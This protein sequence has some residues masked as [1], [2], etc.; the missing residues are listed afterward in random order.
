MSRESIALMDRNYCVT[1]G[2][3]AGK[4][5]CLVEAYLGLVNG[6]GNRQPLEPDQVVA[7]T[8]TEKAAAEMRARVMKVASERAAENGGRWRE[9]LTAL[10]WAPITTIHSFC[11]TVLRDYGAALGIDPDFSIMDADTFGQ[12]L[13]DSVDGLLRRCLSNRAEGLSLL[14]QHYGLGGQWGVAGML[15]EAYHGLATLGV[16]AA[17]AREATALTHDE[18]IGQTEKLAY[19]LV[20]LCDDLSAIIT[21]DEALAKSKA[22][23]AAHLFKFNQQWPGLRSR[24]IAD[25]L[26]S[27]A[28]LCV[29][30]VLGPNQGGPPD[31]KDLRKQAKQRAKDLA[32]GASLPE[33]AM[34]SNALLNLLEGLEIDLAREKARRSSLSFDDLLL[35]SLNLLEHNPNVLHSLRRQFRAV[36]VDEFQDVNPVQ[37]RFVRLLC[38]LS[39][40]RGET[41]ANPLLLV[42]GDRKQ[43]I[44]AFR[45]ADVTFFAQ[46][47]DAFE[48]ET[49]GGLVA[50]Q[51]NFRSHPD[52]ISFFNRVFELVFAQNDDQ[53]QGADSY[54]CF[55]PD[56]CQRPGKDQYA[57]TAGPAVELLDCTE[58][59]DE[60][61][62]T[63]TWRS[64]EANA[65]ANHIAEIIQKTE[66]TPGDIAIL[67]RRMT[68]VALYEQ[69]LNQSGVDFYTVRGRGFY[70]CLEISDMA[71]ALRVLLS[72]YDDLAT[73]AFL[74]SPLVGLNDESL[75]A[76]MHG[77]GNKTSSLSRMLRNNKELPVWCSET[78]A[79]RLAR[80]RELIAMLGP[81]A[82]RMAPADLLAEL[83]AATDYEAVLLAMQPGGQKAANLRKLIENARSFNGGTV[84]YL[85]DL[86]HKLAKG[87]NDPQAPLMGN[88]GEVVQI[89]TIHQ[90]KGLQFP[91]VVLCDLGA[92]RGPTDSLP[93]PGPGGV[94][95]LRPVDFDTGNRPRNTV[96]QALADRRKATEEAEAARLFYVA[97]TRAEN[98][99]VLS[100]TGAKRQGVW[101]KWVN[102]FM[103]DDPA[104]AIIKPQTTMTRYTTD[105]INDNGFGVP[106]NPGP[107]GAKGQAIVEQCLSSGFISPQKVSISVSGMEDW[108]ECPRRFIFTQRLGLD[109]ALMPS[110]N[111]SGKANGE[112]VQRAVMLGSLVHYILETVD[113]DAGKQAVMAAYKHAANS[114]NAPDDCRDDAIAAAS[115]FFDLPIAA[116]LKGLPNTAL[117]R[118]QPFL[119]SLQQDSTALELIGEI[120]LVAVQDDGSWVIADYKVSRGFD[121]AKYRNQ[122]LIYSTAWW[123]MLGRKGIPRAVLVHLKPDGGALHEMNFTDGD[124]AA[125]E[126]RLIL[127]AK[128]IC[129][130]GDA[131]D[132]LQAP[133]DPSCQRDQCPLAQLC[134]EDD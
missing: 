67:L 17:Q 84:L 96:Y 23:F 53:N 109:T 89:M 46:T 8:F 73:A 48:S 78:Q 117:M 99:L 51:R 128:S 7:I 56:D 15:T 66:A 70:Q 74:R 33:A 86:Q 112:N 21:A 85:R 65:V 47:M 9:V 26:D 45:G 100:R 36:M 59:A 14:L 122:M 25:P 81:W 68:Q 55:R 63:A 120:D 92:G 41:E 82:A 130:L 20:G 113:M 133:M 105:L 75:L 76:L 64:V 94:V 6:N 50:L 24:I 108:L 61:D 77:T 28:M 2:A 11:A 119:L 10:E 18:A 4:T 126:Q 90:A 98:K 3:G 132:P 57:D 106:N 91:I 127:A 34:L 27:G 62:N 37:G 107:L 101:A 125:M 129:A 87:D 93:A 111:G 97:C 54:V 35:M 71:M 104:V 22:K 39:D 29:E 38:G 102:E 52:L 115:A 42:V 124:L 13:D 16:S 72:P 131:T 12:L 83:I 118:E 116:Q 134:P 123:R 32:D 19:E 44:Y 79:L 31:I 49:W 58:L 5:T 88:Q 69:A 121:P 60:S 95:S 103:A 114:L 40:E 110:G 1:A 80:A 43:S 30:S